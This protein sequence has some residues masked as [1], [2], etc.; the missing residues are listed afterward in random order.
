MRTSSRAH[1]SIGGPAVALVLA[2]AA[3]GQS[4]GAAAP[5]QPAGAPGT[6]S[7][8]GYE[9]PGGMWMPAQ[10]TA[11]AATLKQLGLE[12][13]PAALTDP[14]SPLLQAVVSLGGCSASFVSPDGLIATN[15]HCVAGGPT[16]CGT[17]RPA[18]SG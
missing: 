11:H 7:P 9:N 13:D 6:G 5:A 16:S 10:M 15:H 18:R 8:A 2:L 3:C 4:G 14:T 1:L 17:A 12:L